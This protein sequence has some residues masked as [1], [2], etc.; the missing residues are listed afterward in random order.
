MSESSSLFFGT[1]FLK[2]ASFICFD[3]I[4]HISFE[5]CKFEETDKTA[6]VTGSLFC[7]KEDFY[8][9]V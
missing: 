2:K 7:L 1:L 9:E 8:H 6:P 3:F 4:K 5:I